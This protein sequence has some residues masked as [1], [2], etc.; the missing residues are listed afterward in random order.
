MDHASQRY[1]ERM[2]NSGDSTWA[3]VLL[4]LPC[5]RPDPGCGEVCGERFERQVHCEAVIVWPESLKQHS[6][7]LISDRSNR[8]DYDQRRLK[9]AETKVGNTRK[10]QSLSGCRWLD[11]LGQSGFEFD[12]CHVHS[13]EFSFGASLECNAAIFFIFIR[14]FIKDLI[15][16]ITRI[17]LCLSRNGCTVQVHA[18]QHSQ[19]NGPTA[20][21]HGL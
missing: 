5:K 6:M 20:V 18:A 12:S 21:P 15:C 9:Q 19:C 16:H 1:L 13:C 2:C 14:L 10:V 4:L 3:L 11:G 17:S 8:A 7:P